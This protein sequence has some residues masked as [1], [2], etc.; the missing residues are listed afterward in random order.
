MHPKLRSLATALG[1][2]VVLLLAPSTA[3]ARPHVQVR[4][5]AYQVQQSLD[6]VPNGQSSVAEPALSPAPDG[7]DAE[8][9]V[10]SARNQSVLSITPDGQQ[11]LVAAGLATDAG[12]PANYASVVADGYDWVLDNDQGPGNVL[13]AVGGA[14]SPSPGLNPVARF[15]DYGQDMT[16]GP[17]GALY[18]ADNSGIIR[19]Q[20][21]AAPS[22]DCRTIQ[23]PPPFYNGAGAFAVGAGGTEAWFTDGAGE[24]G[25]YGASG[26]SGPLPAAG[27]TP[28]SAE[29]GTIATAGNGNVYVAGGSSSTGSN[30]EIL[31]FNPSDPGQ[32]NVVASGLG[33]IVALTVG[34]DGNIWFL[35]DGGSGSLG[36]LDTA[37]GTVTG[38]GLPAGFSLPSSGWR[39]ADG[40]SVPDARGTGE[41]FFTAVSGGGDA[42]I[43][44][45]SGI[46]FPLTAGA[47]AFKGTVTVSRQRLA[48][49]TLTC[50]GE[51]SSGCQGRLALRLRAQLR[52]SVNPAS[53]GA[54]SREQTATR[55]ESLMLGR[56]AYDV[57]GG[58]S[59]H[60]KLRLSPRA[61]RLLERVASKEWNAT[62]SAVTAL[63]TVSGRRLTMA[64]PG[65]PSQPSQGPSGAG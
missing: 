48:V 8:W 34:P 38:Y 17:D 35:N 5:S 26:F 9:F 31:E 39:I 21:T 10:L 1:A 6:P 12:T 64:G 36:M 33:N 7:S 51:S 44:V 20:I 23:I 50:S 63:G 18:V 4:V 16:L 53:R 65:A 27:A 58:D 29:P 60:V 47:L 54:N 24:I 45:V 28:A 55:R 11:S 46:P 15:G 3:G 13:Y 52:L 37:T 19:C 59:V 25:G 30:S 57:S 62:V 40:P 56:V 2:A 22:A 61:Y 14:D 43:G 49:L 41:V 42:A 32:V